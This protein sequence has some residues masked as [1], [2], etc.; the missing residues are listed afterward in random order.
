MILL[1]VFF[2]E[3]TS[4]NFSNLLFTGTRHFKIDLLYNR[5]VLYNRT[6][7]PLILFIFTGVTFGVFGIINFRLAFKALNV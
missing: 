6:I 1:F 2:H 5:I 4:K 3:I 7:S